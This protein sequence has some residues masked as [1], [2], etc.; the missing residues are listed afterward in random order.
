[1][2]AIRSYLDNM[3]AHLPRTEEL[4]RAKEELLQMMEDKYTQLKAEGRTENEAV[5]QVISEFGNLEEVAEQLGISQQVSQVNTK[6]QIIAMNKVEVDQYL[7]ET[8]EATKKIASGVMLIICAVIP[9][10][11]F[12]T[13]AGANVIEAKIATA[14]GI[15]TLFI[16]IAIS[17]YFFIVNGIKT[18]KYEQLERVPVDLD[19]NTLAYVRQMKADY[20]PTFARNIGIGVVL[21]LIGVLLLTTA[22]I[23]ELKPDY[24]K[25]LGVA[26]LLFLVSVATY[27]FITSSSRTE[28]YDRLLNEGDYTKQ[29]K[30]G[31]KFMEIISGPYWML[32]VVGYLAWSFI[33]MAWGISWIVFPI[34]GVLFG[35]IGAIAKTIQSNK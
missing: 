7:T 18:E 33:K 20:L 14:L 2:D 5:G 11:I 24:L 17:V 28:S 21:I 9:L 32:V 35:L 10:L 27:L 6:D 13:L 15:A 4:K 22:S 12:V 26:I 29:G 23:L 1:M 8:H 19:Q 25:V 31:N 30:Q 3:F 34:A 16:A